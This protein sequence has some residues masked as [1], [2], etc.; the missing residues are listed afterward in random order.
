MRHDP[1]NITWITRC[2]HDQI[3]KTQEAAY[4]PA[5]DVMERFLDEANLL[6]DLGVSAI[7]LASLELDL[8]FDNNFKPYK[9]K[10]LKGQSILE[11][12][13]IQKEKVSNYGRLIAVM[14]VL[15]PQFIDNPLRVVYTQAPSN[16]VQS[17][18]EYLASAQ[19]LSA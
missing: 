5:Q 7:R 10:Q 19:L 9:P 1:F 3:H 2:R 4:I 16:V 13:E 15:P 17:A 11:Q 12:M 6:R 8:D 18:T 14:E